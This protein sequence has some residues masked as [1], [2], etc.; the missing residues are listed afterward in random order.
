MPST[1]I[2][3]AVM[4]VTGAGKSSFI[5]TVTQSR[6]VIIGHGLE[7][8]TQ[9]PASYNFSHK[10]CDYT[11][12]DCPG[13]NDT[14]RSD[15]EILQEIVT[16]LSA[17]YGTGNLL[18]GILYLHPI[19]KT[20]VQGSTMTQFCVFRELCGKNFF[21]NVILGTT[22]WQ[23]ASDPDKAA[24]HE[25]ELFSTS[26]FF[27]DMIKLGA[28]TVR[29]SQVR[30]ECL[31]V[32]ELFAGNKKRITK[33][34]DEMKKSGGSFNKT[35]AAGLLNKINSGGLTGWRAW[36]QRRKMEKQDKINRIAMEAEQARVE[37]ERI[38]AEN[39]DR[40]RLR[41]EQK[42]L[43]MEESRRQEELENSRFI[44]QRKLREEREEQD[45]RIAQIQR[46]A[47]AERARQDALRLQQRV[48][49]QQLQT[50]LKEER[51]ERE[52]I[53]IEKIK[54]DTRERL[55]LQWEKKHEL[56]REKKLQA[57]QKYEKQ[58]SRFDMKQ[59]TPGWATS[60]VGRQCG[61]SDCYTKLG[62]SS[63]YWWC[64]ECEVYCCT[65]CYDDKNRK[66]QHFTTCQRAEF[67]GGDEERGLRETGFRQQ[68]PPYPNLVY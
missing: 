64:P 61:Q 4:G 59:Y 37:K 22:F 50:R 15:E 45:R 62:S 60:W 7:S 11:L 27:G 35:S 34:Q 56:W 5:K 48:Q 52:R 20:R 43:D 58:Q 24:K 10:G 47:A 55:I 44:L 54:A 53:R 19:N 14:K 12:I 18:S 6:S 65:K 38:E 41:I 42:R 66:V 46:D 33:A 49:E 21:S 63:A 25:K 23:A 51:D 36:R 1:R 30:K 8:E 17:K 40:E 31:S 32:V 26:E 29:I 39:A 3:I 9:E 2:S 68:E 28:R 16:F 13:F 57:L 67:C